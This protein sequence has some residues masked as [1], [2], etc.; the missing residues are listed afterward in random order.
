MMKRFV[1]LLMVLMLGLSKIFAA[2]A[3]P[4]DYVGE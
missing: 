3:A 2:H 1:S 4:E